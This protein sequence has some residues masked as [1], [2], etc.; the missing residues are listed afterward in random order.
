MKK[1]THP[2]YYSDAISDNVKRAQEQML[3]SGIYPSKPPI[4]YK[5]VPI[6]KDKKDKTEKYSVKSLISEGQR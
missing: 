3:R 2:K 1:D 6:S 4:G 5:R